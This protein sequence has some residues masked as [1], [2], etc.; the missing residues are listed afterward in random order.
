MLASAWATKV[1]SSSTDTLT[2]GSR[3]RAVVDCKPIGD[4]D[5]VALYELEVVG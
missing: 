5:T 3:V 2:V 1:P 4:G